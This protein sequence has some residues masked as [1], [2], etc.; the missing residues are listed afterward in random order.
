MSEYCV[1]SICFEIRNRGPWSPLLHQRAGKLATESELAFICVT[2]TSFPH[3]KLRLFVIHKIIMKMKNE[4]CN[5][6]CLPQFPPV[7]V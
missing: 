4:Q 2:L 7:D 6:V 1:W 3:G 5:N